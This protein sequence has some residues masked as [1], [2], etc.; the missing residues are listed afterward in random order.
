MSALR[1]TQAAWR[2]ALL[3]GEPAG[4]LADLVAGGLPIDSRLAIYRH[5]VA[6]SLSELLESVYPVVCRLVDRRFFGYAADAFISACPPAGPCLF[7]YGAGF[8][9]FLVRLEPCRTLAWLPDVARLEWAMH[10]AWFADD[11]TPLDPRLLAAIPADE[12]AEARVRLDPSVT[13]LTSPFAVDDI[14]RANQP[15]APE[16]LVSADAGPVHLEIRRHGDE[17]FVRRLHAPAWAF[18]SALRAGSTLAE[19]GERALALDESFDLAATF[20]ALFGDDVLVAFT[21]LTRRETP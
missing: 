11:A 1:D 12:R 6:T 7:E 17:V 20:Q 18:R 21:H 5:H 15:G 10:R 8:P 2:T 4:A 13:L 3:G 9:D 16:I 14:W 19:A